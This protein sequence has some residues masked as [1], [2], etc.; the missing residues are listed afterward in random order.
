MTQYLFQ[1]KMNS[2]K[3]FKVDRLYVRN[4][5]G[6][7]IANY[8]IPVARLNFASIERVRISIR[9]DFGPNTDDVS[10]TISTTYMLRHRDTGEENFF[11]GSLHARGLQ[12]GQLTPFRF[13]ALDQFTQHV[14]DRT[15]PGIVDHQL[16][17]VARQT[18]WEFSELVS[19]VVS[20][21]A[22]LLTTRNDVLPARS[23]LDF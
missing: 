2:A 16:G 22:P 23:S 15:A 17:R 18:A 20:V 9:D 14:L 5:C 10:Y 7:V 6:I 12:Y 8:N 11:C 4:N 13:L 19:V 21:Q 3:E 1:S